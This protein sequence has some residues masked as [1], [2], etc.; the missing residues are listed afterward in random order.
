MQNGSVWICRCPKGEPKTSFGWVRLDLFFGDI[1]IYVYICIGIVKQCFYPSG[2]HYD[3]LVATVREAD[4]EV[5]ERYPSPSVTLPNAE[6]IEGHDASLATLFTSKFTELCPNPPN[7]RYGK[8]K[9][10]E[11]MSIY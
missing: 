9:K 3:L 11:H 10:Y 7:P 2:R 4:G 6:V 1:Y 8:Y 5:G